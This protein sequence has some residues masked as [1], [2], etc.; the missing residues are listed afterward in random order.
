MLNL[1]NICYICVETHKLFYCVIGLQQRVATYYCSPNKTSNISKK[2]PLSMHTC[3]LALRDIFHCL[4]M[5]WA[6]VSASL[7]A[8]RILWIKME[9]ISDA[10]TNT[11]FQLT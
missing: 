4:S 2:V 10:N 11:E 7:P 1:F 8:S 9:C 3:A 6:K 5:L